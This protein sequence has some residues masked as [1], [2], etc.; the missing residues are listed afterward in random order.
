M[1]IVPALLLVRFLPRGKRLAVSGTIVIAGLATYGLLAVHSFTAAPEL[2][3]PES[4]AGYSLMGHVGWMLD[5]TAM[6][7]SDLTRKMIDAAAPLIAQRPADLADIH[8]LA[9]L[10]RYVD[11]TVRDDQSRSSGRS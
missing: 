11:V 3:T 7:P 1:L 6:P 10:D 2:R 4:F 8:S 9:T 5:D